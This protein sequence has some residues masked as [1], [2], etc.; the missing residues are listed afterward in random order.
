[1]GRPD[2]AA[3]GR[4]LRP[5]ERMSGPGR[6]VAAARWVARGARGERGAASAHGADRRAPSVRPSPAQAT[7]GNVLAASSPPAPALV[8][9]PPP[10]P[11]PPGFTLPPLGGGLS[12][13]ASA[14]RGAER[15]AGPAPSPPGAADDGA[16]GCLPN[17]GTFEECHRKCKGEGRGVPGSRGALR[18]S[19]CGVGMTPDRGVRCGG[20]PCSRA[21]MGSAGGAAIAGCSAGIAGCG[22]APA[23]G[24][25]R[26]REV[27]RWDRG[28]RGFPGSRGVEWHG[29]GR[30]CNAGIAGCGKPLALGVSGG[31]C[32]DLG[33]QCWDRQVQGSPP[34]SRQP[35]GALSG[36]QDGT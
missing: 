35:W 19:G 12:A 26:G 6:A 17:P 8:G 21:G 2:P 22:G 20:A 10:P 28:V 25:E 1:M 9:L 27:Q 18:L 13:G 30:R 5:T 15:P 32:G 33:V 7:M 16:C 14:G 23:L 4:A 34:R 3:G 24:R 36:E 31:R 29:V 11:A